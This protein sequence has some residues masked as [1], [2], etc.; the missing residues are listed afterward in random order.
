MDFGGRKP[1]VIGDRGY[2]SKDFIRYLE[3]KG[4]RYVL[5]V[6]KGFN[7]RI[8]RMRVESQDITLGEGLRIRALVFPLTS[9]ER[10]ALVTNLTEGEVEEGA[11][12]GLYYKRWPIET[13]YDQIKQKLE[14]ENFSGRLV[15]NIKQDFYAMTTVSNTLSSAL[16]EANRKI[17][18]SGKEKGLKYKYRANVNHAVGVLKDQL[19]EI[20]I[21][22]DLF[23]RKYL[24]WELV[25]EIKRQIVPVRPN[26]KVPR[27]EYL[28]KPHFRHNH[29]SNC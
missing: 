19:I 8:D 2:P 11:F 4:I 20:L 6:Q 22:D 17:G 10:E 23:A 24:Y 26:R 5:R 16:R 14:L 18:E 27:K 28:K 12:P 9:G 25:G 7:S 13:K 21:A 29:K 3:N 1:L 15:D